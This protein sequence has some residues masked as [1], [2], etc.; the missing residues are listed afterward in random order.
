[1]L[2]SFNT[3]Y[4]Q[5]KVRVRRSHGPLI[6]AV[7]NPTLAKMLSTVGDGKPNSKHISVVLVPHLNLS[8]AF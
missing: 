8:L 2:M 7:S 6:E 1:M 4:V 5:W 3:E